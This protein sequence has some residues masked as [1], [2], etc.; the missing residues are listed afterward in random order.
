[1]RRHRWFL[2][3]SVAS[4]VVA[5]VVVLDMLGAFVVSRV[6][7]STRRMSQ[8]EF[9]QR[10]RLRA[11]AEVGSTVR[12]LICGRASGTRWECFITFADGERGVAEVKVRDN[13]MTVHTTIR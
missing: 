4:V 8:T 7:T 11:A 10:V 1:M 3:A 12:H 5:V 9:D 13:T 2:V 6:V